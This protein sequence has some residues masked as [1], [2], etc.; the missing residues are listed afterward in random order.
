MLFLSGICA[1]MGSACFQQELCV[2]S[3]IQPRISELYLNISDVIRLRT[4]T[5]G[6]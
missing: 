5:E 1:D 2:L 3:S 6:K 4:A